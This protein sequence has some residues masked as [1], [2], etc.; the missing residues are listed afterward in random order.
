MRKNDV[1]I[2]SLIFSPN[3]VFDQ[4]KNGSF[5]TARIFSEMKK[6]VETSLNRL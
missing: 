5:F 1:Y 2:T 4:F 3:P 6:A